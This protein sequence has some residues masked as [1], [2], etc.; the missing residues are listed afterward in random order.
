[1]ALA[2]RLEAG[3]PVDSSNSAKLPARVD[4]EEET[5]MAETAPRMS[6]WHMQSCS[7]WLGRSKLLPFRCRGKRH[8]YYFPAP[9]IACAGAASMWPRLCVTW[10]RLEGEGPGRAGEQSLGVILLLLLRLDL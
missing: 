9:V 5:R 8:S 10:S 2:K 6:A 1:M 4:A 3:N 7:W